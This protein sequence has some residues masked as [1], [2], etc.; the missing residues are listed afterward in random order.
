LISRNP[1]GGTW[2]PLIVIALVALPFLGGAAYTAYRSLW[3]Q[4]AAARAEGTV[5]EVS[6]GTPSLTVEYRTAGGEVLRTETGGSDYYRHLANG[7]FVLVFYDPQKPADARVDLWLEHWIVPLILLVPGSLIML[8]AWLIGSGFRSNFFSHRKPLATGGVPVQAEFVRVRV[9]MD[10]DRL[11]ASRRNV[12][13][14]SLTDEDGRCELIHNGEKR[15][16][17]DPAVQ[18][19][20]GLRHIV[21]AR[22]QDPR[23][24][25]ERFY[26]SEPLENNPQRLLEGS[27]ITVYVDPKRPDVYRMELPGQQKKTSTA[28]GQSPITKL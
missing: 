3:F 26:E 21:V 9:G 22:G 12:G 16:P 11:L 14:F 18:R 28:K 8:A 1:H 4:F 27:P 24:G 23:T 7:D 10:M 15:D 25:K 19:E 5:V 2:V 13:S 20:L 6:E 17:F